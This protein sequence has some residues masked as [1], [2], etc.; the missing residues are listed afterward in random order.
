MYRGS[1]DDADDGAKRCRVAAGDVVGDVDN[2]ESGGDYMEDDDDED[3]DFYYATDDDCF[4]EGSDDGAAGGGYPE[5]ETAPDDDDDAGGKRRQRAYA[6]LTEDD[7][8]ARQE[9]DTADVPEVLSIPPSF[10]AVLLRHFKWRPGRVQEEWFTDDR[11]VRGAVGLPPPAA[12]GGG[13]APVV[14]TS[15]S[16]RGICFVRFKA[17]AT[18]SAGCCAH[19]YCDYCWR[20]YVHAAVADGARCLA[21]RCPDPS[22]SAAVVAD[23]VDAV[24]GADERARYALRSYV[25][26][27][28]G[29]I[30]WCPAPG[31]ARAV[32]SLG[33][34]GREAH[35]P[36]PCGTVRA[37]LAKNSS[38]SETASW[39]LAHTKHCPKCR[40]PIEKNQG[41]NHMTCGA[42]CR[43]QFCWLCFDPWNDHTGCSS[44]GDVQRRED[45]DDEEDAPAG[46]ARTRKEEER[47]RQAKASLD[48]YLYHYERW[49]A[50][51]KSMQKAAEDMDQLRG[52]G[53]ERMAAALEIRA[54]DLGFLTEAYELI[55]EGRRR[56]LFDHLQ[57]DANAWLERLHSCAELERRRSFCVDGDSGE[58][59]SAMNE[60]YRAYKKK[61]QDLTKATRTYFGNLVKAFET[62]LPEFNSVK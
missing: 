57:N 45:E 11:R 2:G 58:G 35:R 30:K 7:V 9:K 26:E 20:G 19:Y 18:R 61:L 6:V 40:R 13:G 33:G 38:D 27:S 50:N 44:Y 49:A 5:E 42:P 15:L 32:E 25:E 41:C 60:T 3:N 28:G 31:C 36:V 4:G 1:G 48:R 12:D 21:L 23:L 51:G 52:S 24:A 8:A 16:R 46:G 17:G 55:A 22:C 56:A 47:R 54:A 43:H 34:G 53:L 29:R 62:D 10:A 37:W 59:A 39:V 14:A